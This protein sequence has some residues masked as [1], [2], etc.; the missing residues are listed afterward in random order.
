MCYFDRPKPSMSHE[1]NRILTK[2]TE[3]DK[4]FAELTASIYWKLDQLTESNGNFVKL[5]AYNGSFIK[6]R[7]SN[8]NFIKFRASNGNFIML[9]AFYGN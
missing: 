3:Y 7:A 2:L 8:G 5:T 4:N 9:T 6:L 1:L